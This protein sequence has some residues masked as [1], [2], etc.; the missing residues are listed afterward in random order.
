MESKTIIACSTTRYGL[1]LKLVYK[2]RDIFSE[3]VIL[4]T[5]FRAVR[6]KIQGV[7]RGENG[8]D[9]CIYISILLIIHLCLIRVVVIITTTLSFSFSIITSIS[10]THPST[11]LQ[12]SLTVVVTVAITLSITNCIVLAAILSLSSISSDSDTRLYYNE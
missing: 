12:H 11:P 8:G 6:R 4:V 3:N 9:Q 2:F 10:I 1:I 7:S 5:L